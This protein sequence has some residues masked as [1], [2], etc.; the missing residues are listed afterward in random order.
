VPKEKDSLIDLSD[1]ASGGLSSKLTGL[2]IAGTAASQLS[3][4]SS[5]PAQSG[6]STKSVPPD[7]VSDEFDML[8]QSR[9]TQGDNSKGWVESID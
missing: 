2:S 6:S 5:V 3:Q 7:V 9:N 4:I 8:A 1:E